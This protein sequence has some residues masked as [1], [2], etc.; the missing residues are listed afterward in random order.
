MDDIGSSGVWHG[1]F[2][3][4][5]PAG[6]VQVD[7]PTGHTCW[8]L[9]ALGLLSD[10]QAV[11]FLLSA[12]ACPQDILIDDLREAMTVLPRLHRYT[13]EE[14]RRR[15]GSHSFAKLREVSA[16]AT[17]WEIGLRLRAPLLKGYDIDIWHTPPVVMAFHLSQVEALHRRA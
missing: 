7:I 10:E 4:R 5:L 1:P 16:W 8:H 11:R 2:R 3:G 9:L 6:T 15:K 17:P 13:M 14:G 12:E